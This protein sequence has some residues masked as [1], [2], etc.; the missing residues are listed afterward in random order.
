VPTTEELEGGFDLGEWEVLPGQ[1]LLRR[2]FEEVRPEPKVMSVLLALARR[3]G[4][5]VTKEQLIEEV[6][7]GSAFSD[8]PIQRCIALIRGHL[9][10]TRPYQYIE[11]LQRRG[12]R[13]LKP[14]DLHSRMAADESDMSEG[15]SVRLWKTIAAVVAVGFVA[16]AVLSWGPWSK[17]S[18]RA[19]AIMPIENLSGD[20]GNQYVVDGIKNVLAQRLTEL[21]EFTIK[22]VKGVYEGEAQDVARMLGVESAL[23]GSVQL[24][25]GTLQVG[26]EIVRGDDGV[27]IAAGE[28]TGELDNVFGLQVRLANAIRHEFAGSQTPELIKRIEPDSAAY[29]SYLRGMYALEHRFEPENIEESI[30]LFEESIKV[31]ESYGP[32]YL[33]LATAYALMPDY[34]GEAWDEYLEL[35]IDTIE[36]GVRLDSSLEAPAGAIYGF[37]YYQKKDWQKAEENYLRAVTAPVVDVNAF[38][39]YSMMQASTGRMESA[40]EI[41]VAPLEFDSQ[42]TVLNSRVAMIHTWMNDRVKAHDYFERAN[43]LHATGILHDMAYA[44]FLLRGGDVEV[45]Q[46]L[47]YS[48]AKAAD[49]SADWVGPVFGAFVDPAMAAE[50][51]AAVNEAWEAEPRQVPP[52][53]VLLA[54][55]LLNDVDGAMEIARRLE[56]PG[57]NLNMELLFI[58]ELAPVRQHPDFLPLL[59]SLGVVDYWATVGCEWTNDRVRCE[60]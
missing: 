55:A 28:V 5:L 1:G 21:P 7:G 12:Y 17:P 27:I 2:G 39:W 15:R 16:V 40:L 36:Q 58:R 41:A 42:N 18:T 22:N 4:N 29:N 38:S 11:T 53:V 51:L 25:N 47:A 54:R 52:N 10:D 33:G 26:Y 20:P 3:D 50:G 60:R 6:W 23:Y 34:R 24:Q 13:L 9:H 46:G 49:M 30:R 8:E 35:A 56:Q 37:Y 31:D 43:R 45:A 44:L 14:V 57:S 48:T 19:L 59:E 32:A